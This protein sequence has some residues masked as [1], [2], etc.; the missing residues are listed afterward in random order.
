MLVFRVNSFGFLF[1]N[2][3]G[4][5]TSLLVHSFIQTHV[6]SFFGFYF[7][8]FG[9]FL[10]V[11]CFYTGWNV[12]GPLIFFNTEKYFVFEVLLIMNAF[13]LYFAADINLLLRTDFSCFAR[14]C[15]QSCV[16]ETPDL[17]I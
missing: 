6:I 13:L 16:K 14:L 1:L 7:Q 5:L 17:L 2:V 9:Q 15:L 12:L 10:L 11:R 4:A 3:D 8:D